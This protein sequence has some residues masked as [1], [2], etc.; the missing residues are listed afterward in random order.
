[1]D[2]TVLIPTMNRHEYLARALEYYKV[3]KF[4]GYIFIGDSSTGEQLRKNVEMIDLIKETESLNIIYR[5]YPNPPHLHD[6][7]AVQAMNEEVST[8][9]VA[10]TGDDDFFIVP[11]IQKSIEFL[12]HNSDFIGVHGKRIGMKLRDDEPYGDLFQWAIYPE[13]NWIKDNALDRW[14]DYTQHPLSSQAWVFYADIWKRAYGKSDQVPCRYLGP[15]YLPCSMQAILGKSKELDFVSSICQTGKLHQIFDFDKTPLFDLINSALWPQ[16]I[17]VVKETIINA[18]YSL[19]PTAEM[20]RYVEHIVYGEMWRH[21][22]YFMGQQYHRRF[23]P[24]EK[25]KLDYLRDYEG[26]QIMIVDPDWEF[27][28]DFKPIYDILIKDKPYKDEVYKELTIL[29]EGVRK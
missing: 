17:Q 3:M 19:N 25:D 16:S 23:K 29:T 20:L 9:Y 27:F 26:D 10:Q 15:E 22:A 24:E 2:L 28:E 6:G 1:M 21:I 14:I 4:D 18:I 5:M 13:Q 7:M 12:E 11:N 8:K